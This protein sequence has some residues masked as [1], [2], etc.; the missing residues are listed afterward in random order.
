MSRCCRL[1]FVVLVCGGRSYASRASVF[2]ALDRVHL[3]TEEIVRVIHGD[4]RRLVKGEWVGA[5]HFAGEWAESRGVY[6]DPYP[7][8]WTKYGKGA[9]PIRNSK[10]LMEGA[11]DLVIAF[12]GGTG[13]A[14]MVDKARK[15]GIKVWEP[16]SL[17]TCRCC[18]EEE[19]CFACDTCCSTCADEINWGGDER[20]EEGL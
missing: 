7:A 5:D 16:G 17:V 6:C 1:P 2:A 4:A 9:G 8:D 12:P 15:Q 11:P 10:M 13:T 3:R 14:D 20:Q 19:A 18:G